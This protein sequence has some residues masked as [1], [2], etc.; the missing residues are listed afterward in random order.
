[1]GEC[2]CV[3]LC[4]MHCVR[5]I[6]CVRTYVRTCVRASERANERVCVCVYWFLWV[7]CYIIDFSKDNANVL[8]SLG[9]IISFD[10][11]VRI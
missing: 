9:K 6:V 2:T 5:A 1:M 8:E 11:V 3:R 7:N 4:A 10:C